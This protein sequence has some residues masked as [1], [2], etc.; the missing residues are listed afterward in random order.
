MKQ[1]LTVRG[2]AAAVAAA[3]VLSATACSGDQSLLPPDRAVPLMEGGVLVG[4]GH[5]AKAGDANTTTT[6]TTT[7]AQDSAGRGPG[8]IGSGH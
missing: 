4:S 7:T 2:I 6:T 1:A 8:T 5:D 3:C